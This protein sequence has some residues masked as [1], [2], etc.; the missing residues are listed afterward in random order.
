[1]AEGSFSL[2]YDGPAVAD[3][4]MRVSDLAPALLALGDLVTGTH[5]VVHPGSPPLEVD[6]RSTRQGSFVVEMLAVLAERAPELLVS[7]EATSIANTVAIVTGAHGIFDYLR[8][9]RGRR[10]VDQES[11]TDPESGAE[12]IRITLEDGAVI[13]APADLV[14]AG[15]AIEIRRHAKGVV[16]PLRRD[17]IEGVSFE[18]DE[19]ETT[20][21]VGPEDVDAF[22]VPDDG[23]DG[24]PEP[25]HAEVV[26]R[27]RTVSLEDGGAWRM[28]DGQGRS[29]SV[30]FEDESFMRSV[31]SK[32]QPIGLGDRLVARIRTEPG[33]G[34]KWDRHY[35]EEVLNVLPNPN[36]QQELQVGETGDG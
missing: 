35:V 20:V 34:R 14:R 24:E 31:Q 13:D 26:L 21:R 6:I 32:R 36:V 9:L 1:M 23:V 30:V 25:V 18:A 2:R 5:R 10:I 4:S 27:P 11:I 28:T 29:L 16:N 33:A 3:G 19:V 17:G 22:D 7:D 8:I 12:V 15:N